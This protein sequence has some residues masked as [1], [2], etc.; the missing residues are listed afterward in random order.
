M[1][2]VKA[3]FGSIIFLK[4]VLKVTVIFNKKNV[5]FNPPYRKINQLTAFFAFLE[6]GQK[7]LSNYQK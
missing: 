2:C 7:P 5:F 1:K 6:S 3:I 4:S